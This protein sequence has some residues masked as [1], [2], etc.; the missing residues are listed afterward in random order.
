MRSRPR[1]AQG[2]AAVAVL[3][4]LTTVPLTADAVPAEDSSPS[5]TVEVPTKTVIPLGKVTAT[6]KPQT[7]I[8]FA[9]FNVR[10]SRAD[11]GTSHHW[12]HRV[13]SVAREIKSRNPG[14]VAIQELGP[15]RADG[16]KGKLHGATRQTTSLERA[17]GRIGAGKYRLVR[18]TAYVKPGSNHGTQGARIL[19]DTSRF[20]LV[21]HCPE[22]TGKKNY[23][24]ACSLNTPILGRDGRGQTRSAAYA[25]FKHKA[26]GKKF[27]AISVHLDDRH[28]GSRS[29]E[30]AYDNLRRSQIR[31]AYNR[32]QGLNGA[33]V[34]VI[35]GGDINSWRTKSGSDAPRSY[36]LGQGLRDSVNAPRKVDARY[37]TVNH[38]KR[39][40]RANAPGRQVAL[41]I[42]MVKGRVTF[43]RYENVMQVADS[44]RSSDHNMV[45]SDLVLDPAEA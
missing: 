9:T 16:K 20:S 23:N 4:L 30:R 43:S 5:T 2:I 22:T 14:I 35:V 37:P 45:V 17:L 18:E 36:L 34:P 31:A 11:R 32:V 40:L 8:R 10:T 3:G 27:W 19:Y 21:S 24:Y 28:S 7:A 33:R 41:D 26:T 42:V 44:S 6:L 1:V 25:Q 13:G 38:F 12:L 29:K 15:G 39:V